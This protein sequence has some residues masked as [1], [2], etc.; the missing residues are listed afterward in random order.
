MLLHKEWFSPQN[1]DRLI[2]NFKK[3]GWEVWYISKGVASKH[4]DVFEDTTPQ[5][6]YQP[7][8]DYYSAHHIGRICLTKEGQKTITLYKGDGFTNFMRDD[9]EKMHWWYCVVNNDDLTDQI[10]NM[11]SPPKRRAS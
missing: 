10:M 2:W 8:V 5:M 4:C 6:H 1:C 9:P 7:R 3:Q 11:F